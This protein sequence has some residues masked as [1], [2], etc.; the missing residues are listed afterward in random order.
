[1]TNLDQR[2]NF[3]MEHQL[4]NN[5]CWA[6]TGK[7]VSHFYSVQS[8]WTQCKIAKKELGLSTCCADRSTC[9]VPWTLDTTLIRTGNFVRQFHGN[10]EWKDIKDEITAGHI[11]CAFIKWEDG[12]GH[13]VAIYGVAQTGGSKK[14]YIGDPINGYKLVGY[15]R[16]RDNYLDLGSWDHTYL[17]KSNDSPT[18]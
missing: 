9:D 7:S 4:A 12:G 8:T 16:F 15:V 6:A 3:N 1:M 18:N 14:V 2:L 5:W 10:M 13:F 11:V 17:T